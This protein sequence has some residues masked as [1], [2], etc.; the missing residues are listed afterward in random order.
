MRSAFAVSL[1]LRRRRRPVHGCAVR[2]AFGVFGVAGL[3]AFTTGAAEAQVKPDSGRGWE[4]IVPGGTVVPTGHQRDAVKRG[5]LTALQ[6]SYRLGPSLALTTTLGWA[7]LRDAALDGSPKVDLLTLD[8][9]AEGRGPRWRSGALSF[10]PFAG[11]GVGGRRYDYRRGDARATY[12]P[13]AYAGLGGEIGAGR[14]HL[15]VEARDY[16]SRFTPLGGV[17]TDVVRNDVALL[18]GLRFGSR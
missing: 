15:R 1:T 12:G 5:G 13:A 2:V 9:G 3:L 14:V 16:V 18:V 8:L 6:V 10:R 17:G 4:L 11:V 7:R